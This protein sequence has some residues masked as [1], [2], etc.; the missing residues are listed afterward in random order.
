MGGLKQGPWQWGGGRR[1][2]KFTKLLYNCHD[3]DRIDLC[4]FTKLGAGLLS[5]QNMKRA[6]KTG[7]R[8]TARVSGR[9]FDTFEPALVKRN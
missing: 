1:G 6:N 5:A 9:I 3:N 4:I 2:V 8:S 7:S